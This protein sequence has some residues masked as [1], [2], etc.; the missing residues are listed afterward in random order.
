MKLMPEKTVKDI[1][2]KKLA[3]KTL[4]A[5]GQ[6]SEEESQRYYDAVWK[7][8]AQKSWKEKLDLVTDMV[9]AAKKAKKGANK[10]KVAMKTQRGAQKSALKGAAVQVK[11]EKTPATI[12]LLESSDE[13]S[14]ASAPTATLA[15]STPAAASAPGEKAK[16]AGDK[17]TTMEDDSDWESEDVTRISGP[18]ELKVVL[19]ECAKMMVVIE[20]ECKDTWPGLSLDAAL[21]ARN[22]KAKADLAAS[23]AAAK[24]AA[25][26]AGDKRKAG[27]EDS[28]SESE[29]V[30]E[31]YPQTC[32][33][34]WSG[35]SCTGNRYR[36]GGR[37]Q[38][39]L[40]QAFN[41]AKKDAKKTKKT[42]AARSAGGGGPS[43]SD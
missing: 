12:E 2:A 37:C 17:R 23:R 8:R 32:G 29:D 1:G 24:A 6:L 34:K 25:K 21:E 15:A 30:H 13:E 36:K 16:G 26:G 19:D 18:E 7:Q 28:E 38:G 5:W 33:K 35:V 42:D 4:A 14:A 11:K 3:F 41:Q 9:A 10:A 31:G 27:E 39:G 22:Q 20:K 43:D 40:C